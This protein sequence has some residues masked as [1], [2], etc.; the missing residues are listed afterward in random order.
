MSDFMLDTRRALS[1]TDEDERIQILRE[2][3]R[4]CSEILMAIG[5]E[6]DSCAPWYGTADTLD[7]RYTPLPYV[8]HMPSLHISQISSLHIAQMPPPFDP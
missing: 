6:P 3:E 1:T 2:I 8:P 4:S 7:M 5:I